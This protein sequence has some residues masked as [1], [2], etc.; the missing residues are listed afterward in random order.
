MQRLYLAKVEKGRNF[1]FQ[2]HA[3]ATDHQRWTVDLGKIF[4]NLE[5]PPPY[6]AFSRCITPT[7]CG[8]RLGIVAYAVFTMMTARTVYFS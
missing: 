3:K 1:S 2:T 7:L 6:L 8:R 4:Y 5:V